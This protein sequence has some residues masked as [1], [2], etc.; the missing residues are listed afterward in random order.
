MDILCF[1]M[2][3]HIR[4]ELVELEA[5]YGVSALMYEKPIAVSIVEARHIYELCRDNGI[6]AIICYQHKFLLSF[7]K[8]WEHIDNGRFGK[9]LKISAECLSW[10]GQ[11][12]THYTDILSGPM[13]ALKWKA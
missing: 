3:P 6:K 11:I 12:A 2:L 1:A 10:I 4:L 9:I 8:L 5:K 7:L 13:A